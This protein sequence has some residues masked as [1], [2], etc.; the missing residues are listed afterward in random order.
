MVAKPRQVCGVPGCP[1]LSVK[2]GRCGQHQREAWAGRPPAHQRGYGWAWSKLRAQVL[3]EEPACR[4]CGAV[5]V[6]VHHK[7]KGSTA[8]QNLV[9]LCKSCHDKVTARQS[10]WARR[11]TS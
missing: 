11:N 2:G 4:V 5:A 10:A 9:P 1:R 3:T 6:T 7:V 8:R